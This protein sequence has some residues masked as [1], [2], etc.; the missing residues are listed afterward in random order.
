MRVPSSGDLN[1]V[2][3]VVEALLKPGGVAGMHPEHPRVGRLFMRAV[4]MLDG[5]LRFA[6]LLSAHCVRRIV[7]DVLSSP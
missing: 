4:C 1:V 6:S 5:E 2:C 3:D 7:P